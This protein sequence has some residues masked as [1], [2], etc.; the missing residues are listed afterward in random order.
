MIYV[1]AFIEIKR[2]FNQ[3]SKHIH[4]SKQRHHHP[5]KNI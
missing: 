5:Q 2:D 1:V 3:I 4:K